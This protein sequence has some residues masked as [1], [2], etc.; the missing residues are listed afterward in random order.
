MIAF[1][2]DHRLLRLEAARADRRHPLVFRLLHQQRRV[3]EQIQIADMIA[4]L[5]RER[6]VTNVRRLEP[7]L[8]ELAGERF[9]AGP[10]AGSTLLP[11][12]HVHD[13]VGQSRVPQQPTLRVMHQVTVFGHRHRPAG[14]DARPARN[15][16][17]DT[18][19][20]IEDI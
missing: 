17:S 20:A 6:K 11:V 5:V 16:A 18:F 2:L 10:H 4:M 13:R 14:I 12:R 19:A 15:V 7:E 1:R 8:R 3:R 9:L